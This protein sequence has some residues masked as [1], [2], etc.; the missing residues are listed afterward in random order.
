MKMLVNVSLSKNKKEKISEG[1]TFEM[2][3]GGVLGLQKQENER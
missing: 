3:S 2:E 1:H